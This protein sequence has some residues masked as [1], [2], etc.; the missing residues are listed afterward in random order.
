MTGLFLYALVSAGLGQFLPR[1]RLS[2]TPFVGLGFFGGYVTF[3]LAFYVLHV[4]AEVPLAASAWIIVVTAIFGVLWAA[5]RFFDQAERNLSLL[6][7][8]VSIMTLIGAGAIVA[9]GGIDYLPYTSDEFNG[10]LGASRHIFMAGGYDQVRDVIRLPDYTPGWRLVVLYPW[11][12]TGAI[13]EG[14]SAAA[15]FVVHVGLAGLIYDIVVW[16]LRRLR[17]FPEF[18]VALFAWIVLLVGL[19]VE[20]AGLAWIRTLLIEQPQIYTLAAVSLLIVV[21]SV[22]PDANSALAVYAGLTLAC[23]YVLKAAAMAFAPAVG[24]FILAIA[25]SEGHRRGLFAARVLA[26]A[27]Q[28]LG[29]LL[30]AMI[31]WRFV[32]PAAGGGLPSVLDALGS[33]YLAKALEK[34]WRDLAERYFAA[35]WTYGAEYKAPLTALSLFVVL[36]AAMRGRYAAVLVWGGFFAVYMLALYWYQ[37]AA[38]GDYYFQTLDSTP[39]YTRVP[40]QVLHVVGFVVAIMEGTDILVGR[41]WER[42]LSFAGGRTTIV[43][44]AASVAGLIGFQGYQ[45]FRSVDDVTTRAY[46]KTDPRIAEVKQ[47]VGILTRLA[48]R[49]LPDKPALMLIS[50]GQDSEPLN[51][52]GYF[53]R[54]AHPSDAV[55]VGI[56][57]GGVS[58]TAGEPQNVWQQKTTAPALRDAFLATD[59]IWPLALDPWVTSVLAGIVDDPACVNAPLQYYFIRRSGKEGNRVFSCVT[60]K[61]P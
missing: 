13:H 28:L 2:G 7:H 25:W 27:G 55:G 44:A 49:E 24:V 41:R 23:S 36:I 34:D 10:W 12:V 60:K 54:G 8:P 56:T 30:V 31:S 61:A 46:Q 17:M 38:F 20:I 32:S 29:P 9:N 18:H 53:A 57:L 3:V 33:D 37:L 5:K 22:Q 39:R 4:V 43:V 15:P 59:M 45:I 52:A 40:I 21:M 50:Q 6:L 11:A 35:A 48:G 47:A 26:M 51:Y 42:I 14:D 19:A 1:I 58:W 16:Q